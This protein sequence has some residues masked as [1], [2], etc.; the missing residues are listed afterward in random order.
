MSLGAR[1]RQAL[2]R[3]ADDLACSDPR[4]A[5]LLAT[6]SGLTSGE[7]MPACEEVRA[8]WRRYARGARRTGRSW[9]CGHGRGL[10]RRLGFK[11]AVLLLCLA[12]VAGLV[13]VAVT[14]NRAGD[15]SAGACTRSQ[16]APCAHD[17]LR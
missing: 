5:A 12:I 17:W 6:F 1:E 8:G 9:V 13:A 10:G 2:D 14:V 11:V 3:M 16:A 4:L 15:G 7:E